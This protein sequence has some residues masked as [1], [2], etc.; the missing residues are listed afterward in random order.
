M[1]YNFIML[2]GFAP[3]SADQG[4]ERVKEMVTLQVWILLG[5]RNVVRGTIRYLSEMHRA[6]TQTTAPSCSADFPAKAR[7]VRRAVDEGRV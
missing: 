1:Q 3:K 6:K 2:E 7:E 4:S 5:V